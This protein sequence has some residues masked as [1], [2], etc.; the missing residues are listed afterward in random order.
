MDTSA[1]IALAI[2]RPAVYCTSPFLPNLHTLKWTAN[3]SNALT[4]CLTFVSPSLKSLTVN[5]VGPEVP[6]AERSDATGG[7]LCNVAQIAPR[8]K[9][10]HLIVDR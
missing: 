7:F 9:Q 8:L 10:I 6:T 1:F 4:C 2:Q 5:A 3:T